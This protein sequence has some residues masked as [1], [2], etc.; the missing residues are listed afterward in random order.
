[1]R[2]A[3]FEAYRPGVIRHCARQKGREFIADI[4][5]VGAQE[6]VGGESG[7]EV[8]QR[9]IVL[10]YDVG[11]AGISRFAAELDEVSTCL[12]REFRCNSRPV[13]FLVVRIRLAQI[14]VPDGDLREVNREL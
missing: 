13:R 1:M 2:V 10:S 9:A 6:G 12:V 14:G 4:P 11:P 7:L 8:E 5:G 3:D